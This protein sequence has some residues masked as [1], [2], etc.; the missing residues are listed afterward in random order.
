MRIVCMCLA[1]LA[2]CGGSGGNEPVPAF[3]IEA[4]QSPTTVA[5]PFHEG[6]GTTFA[7][8]RVFTALTFDRPVKK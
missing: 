3:G 8:E 6:Q 5:F 2:A 7:R 1:L 4:R